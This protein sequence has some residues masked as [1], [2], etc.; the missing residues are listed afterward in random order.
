MYSLKYWSKYCTL[1]VRLTADGFFVLLL[2][3][4]VLLLSCNGRVQSDLGE[5]WRFVMVLVCPV[6]IP[7]TQHCVVNAK[8]SLLVRCHGRGHHSQLEIFG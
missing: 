7:I 3:S 8:R 5:L 1:L 6:E 4:H 2:F